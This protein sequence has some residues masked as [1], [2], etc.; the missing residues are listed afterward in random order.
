MMSAQTARLVVFGVLLVHGLGH[1]GALAA[2][3]WR[4]YASSAA[5][6]QAGWLAAR[7]WALPSMAPATAT[8]VAS[9]FWIVAMVGFVAAALSFWTGS[10]TG[11]GV[12]GRRLLARLA[13]RHP[14]LPGNVAHLQHDR[15]HVS[16]HRRARHPARTALASDGR[17]RI[18][19]VADQGE[20]KSH[21]H[22][23]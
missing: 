14:A 9:I 4:R 17:R 15:R 19:A 12:A 10:G 2:L 13:I 18:S 16:E 21:G 3:L 5:A 23:Q 6:D 1:G 7:S 11:V 22:T 8:T 20:E